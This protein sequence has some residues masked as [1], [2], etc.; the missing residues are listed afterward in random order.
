MPWLRITQT[1]NRE[2]AEPLAAALEELGA[3]AVT[4]EDA[5][6]EP[7]LAVA[8]EDTP[9]WSAVRVVALFPPDTH[10]E[11]LMQRVA[12]RL[13]DDTPPRWTQDI[14]ADQDWERAWM[15]RYRPIHCGG[16][17]WICPSWHAPPDPDA[18]NV[19]LDPGLAFGTGTHATT[20]LCLAWLAAHPPVGLT[21][22]DYGCG[23]GIL[24]VAAL[25]LG[26]RRVLGLD[27]DPQALGVSRANAARNGVA[28]RLD[29]AQPMTSAAPPA[30]DLV[31]ANILARPLIELAPVIRACVRPGGM[32]VLSGMLAEQVEEVSDHYR[33]EFD[34]TSTLRDGWAMLTGQRRAPG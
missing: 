33:G 8:T 18:V 27:V 4:L 31:L 29:L 11:T 28:E 16:R 21:V 14:L 2:T 22:I 1:T 15:D 13:A 25:K 34:L 5:G 19:L 26:A 23:S 3:I 24:A 20:A 6:D 7:V 9:L 12:A 30:A 10:A 32:L 17:L